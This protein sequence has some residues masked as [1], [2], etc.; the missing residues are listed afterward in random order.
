MK[1]YLLTFTLLIYAYTAF[2]QVRGWNNRIVVD[3]NIEM[4]LP[5]KP[6]VRDTAGSKF[7]M[8]DMDTMVVLLSRLH[9]PAPVPN[10]RALTEHYDGLSQGFL[11]EVNGELIDMYDTTLSELRL[12]T[13]FFKYSYPKP[14]KP[15]GPAFRPGVDTATQTDYRRCWFW[16]IG[17]EVYALQYWYMAPSGALHQAFADSLISNIEFASTLTAEDQFSKSQRRDMNWYFFAGAVVFLA[18]SFIL[19]RRMRRA[20]V[21]K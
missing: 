19:V 16:L 8:L 13:L 1:T 5:A 20:G 12:R 17:Q 21:G 4:L 10:P 3:G 14:A 18:L 6:E 15:F 2:A 11:A 7:V 9:S